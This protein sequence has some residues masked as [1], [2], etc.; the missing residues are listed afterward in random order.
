MIQTKNQNRTEAPLEP[1]GAES[2][3]RNFGAGGGEGILL[4]HPGTQ[5]SHKLAEQLEK[6]GILFCFATGLAF[7]NDS[8]LLK[9]L[10]SSL[11]KKLQRRQVLVPGKKLYTFPLLEFWALR[12]TRR[13]HN[14]EKIFYRRNKRFQ[15]KIPQR[16]IENASVVIGFDTSSWILIDRC[17]K[18]GKRFILDASIAHP[19]SQ[20]AV[21][22]E[23]RVRFPLWASH[24][25]PK[26]QFLLDIELRE[27]CGAETIVVASEFTRNTYKEHGIPVSRI[28]INHYG[29]DIRH[30]KSRWNNHHPVNTSAIRFL[31]FSKLSVRKGFPW[32][33]DV[34]EP[35]HHQNPN[36]IL[37][38]AGYGQL[39]DGFKLPNGIEIQGF[40]HPND[41]LALL[42]SADVF[43]FPSY[44]EGF[45]QVIIEAMACGLPVIT[46]TATVG[47]EVIKNGEQ[48]FIIEP[49][50]DLA[51]KNAMDYFIQNPGAIEP[52]G[53][54]ARKVVESLTWDAY[55]ERWKDIC[56]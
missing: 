10:P 56:Q 39:P 53:K 17:K 37:V 24:L 15:Q 42:H 52:M 1:Q 45:A 4:T 35:F 26:A 54:K 12:N 47:P 11:R 7:G 40:V 32:L 6:Q 30:F 20:Q 2:A 34:W 33:C 48:G 29:T 21:F 22:N 49:G 31:F 16:L 36:T 44:F 55:G 43:V 28:Q 23:L 3:G 38:A 50:N 14:S 46:T 8:L 25:P 5:Y 9:C 51:L 41:R 13:G 27:M 19:L 18:A